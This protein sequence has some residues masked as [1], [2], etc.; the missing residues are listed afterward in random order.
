M[1]SSGTSIASPQRRHNI[2]DG[3]NVHVHAGAGPAGAVRAGGRRDAARRGRRL[4]PRRARAPPA[5]QHPAIA[6]GLQAGRR[7]PAVITGTVLTLFSDSKERSLF[8]A[9]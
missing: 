8:T 4:A 6:H 9:D 1:F 2:R 7:Q 3:S 5:R